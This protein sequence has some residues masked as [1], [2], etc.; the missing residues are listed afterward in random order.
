MTDDDA[1]ENVAAT[2]DMANEFVDDRCESDISGIATDDTDLSTQSN[3]GD[4]SLTA[5][6]VVRSYRH[7]PNPT[8]NT[9]LTRVA[10]IALLF[11]FGIGIGHYIGSPYFHFLDKC[12]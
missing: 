1:D 5:G 4:V 11:A 3:L 6:N 12:T 7:Q 9:T 8:F 2:E 10:L